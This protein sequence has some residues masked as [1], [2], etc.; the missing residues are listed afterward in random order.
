M[1]GC[2]G[3]SPKRSKIWLPKPATSVS[4]SL[5]TTGRPPLLPYNLTRPSSTH[6]APVIVPSPNS[7]PTK[8]S[9][10]IR[11]RSNVLTS[12]HEQAR[13]RCELHI[14]LGV[15]Q[16]QAGIPEHRQTLLD[17][18][19]EATHLHDT[20]RLV[21]AALA[22]TRGSESSTGEID[23]D[24]VRVLRA[25]LDALGPVVTAARAHLLANLAIELTY[26]SDPAGRA[27][28]V[29]EAVELAR[30][31]DEPATLLH[32]LNAWNG[33]LRLPE[34]L[35]ER[36]TATREALA[37]AQDL[38]DPEREF[39]AYRQKLQ[40][41]LESNDRA[42]ADQATRAMHE[43]AIRVGQPLSAVER[44]SKPSAQRSVQW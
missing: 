39:S 40:A 18:A 21:R 32:C 10:S 37:L 22:N 5:P 8:Q 44:L 16:L 4:A 34:T 33:S 35:H 19:A 3:V 20:D 15:A 13:L 9:A 38:D 25:A 26:E 28:L 36:L 23:H 12:E 7:P 42:G 11:T 43:I 27:A 24:R 14:N 2:T 31:V 41:A 17:A 30:Q 1:V 29:T 6:A